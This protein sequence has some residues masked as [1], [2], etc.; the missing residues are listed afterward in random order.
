ML[1]YSSSTINHIHYSTTIFTCYYIY[2]HSNH[3][4][5]RQQERKSSCECWNLQE[6]GHLTCNS[7]LIEYNIVVYTLSMIKTVSNY[8]VFPFN[9]IWCGSRMKNITM[10]FR[11]V[12]SIAKQN[13][14]ITLF[15]TDSDERI[16]KID[17]NYH[18]SV[19]VFVFIACFHG[20]IIKFWNISITA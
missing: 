17:H 19:C 10:C 8:I 5:T 12:F 16:L 1:I 4:P 15:H 20:I 2:A 11:I 13:R 3:L 9:K 14:F 6:S 7:N 18:P